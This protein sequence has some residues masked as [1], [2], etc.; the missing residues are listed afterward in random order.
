MIRRGAYKFIHSPVDPD[1]LFDLTRDPHERGNLAE[2]PSSLESSLI[3]ARRLE[4]AGTWPSWMRF[5]IAEPAPSRRRRAQQGRSA[6]VGFP[7]VP[8]GVSSIRPQ[9][10]GP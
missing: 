8:E 1:Q 9:F 3:F 5:A 7:A 10:D 6:R 4:S 2:G